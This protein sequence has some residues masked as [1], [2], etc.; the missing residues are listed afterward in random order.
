[1]VMTTSVYVDPKTGGVHAG[2]QQFRNR[3]INGDMR[4]NQRSA[5]SPYNITNLTRSTIDRM[6]SSYILNGSF[7]CIQDTDVPSGE[8]FKYSHKYTINTATTA[9]DYGSQINHAIEGYNVS[10]FNW[11]TTSGSYV[12]LSFWTKITGISNGSIL[13]IK[14]Y[15]YGVNTYTIQL[16]YTVAT[17]G[18]WQYVV[19]TIPPPPTAAGASSAKNGAYLQIVF[20]LSSSGHGSQQTLNAW[21]NSNSLFRIVG[22][23]DLASTS[24]WIRWITGL[25]L[26]KGPVATPFELRPY[27]IELQL[28]LRY[29]WRLQGGGYGPL[30]IAS[31]VAP[32]YKRFHINF[33]V[34]MRSAPSF[35][36]SGNIQ[37]DPTSATFT[38]ASTIELNSTNNINSCAFYTISSSGTVGDCYYMYISSSTGYMDFNAEL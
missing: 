7:T 35:T 27:A 36:L 2:L 33:P 10:D 16:S 26:E 21:S 30:A 1:M 15:Y 8:Q 18:N 22:G 38:S 14:I 24:G 11:G 5:E 37:C 31:Q 3:I 28:C 12:T 29:F 19:L 13:P 20:S 23:I 9:N 6:S 17:S 4:I 34:P 32:I 25:Q